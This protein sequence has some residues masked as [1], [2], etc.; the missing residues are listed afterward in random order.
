LCDILAA[1]YASADIFH[2]CIVKVIASREL[3]L[4]FFL[5]FHIFA[6]FKD[7]TCPPVGWNLMGNESRRAAVAL[8][9][10]IKDV[11]S[12]GLWLLDRSWRYICFGQHCLQISAK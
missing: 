11:A 8:A 3:I 4:A 1:V 5:H 7:V 10:R 9:V 2:V 6:L 12:V